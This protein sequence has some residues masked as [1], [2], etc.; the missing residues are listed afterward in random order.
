MAV[1]DIN[2]FSMYLC[3]GMD[4][5]V[6]LPDEIYDEEK[7]KCVWLY[8]GGSGDHKE[9]MYHTPLVDIVNERKFAAVLPNVNESCFVDM[10]IGD[11]YGSYVGKELPK[12]IWKMFNCISGKREDNYVSGLSNGGYGCLHTALKYPENFSV[13][14]AFSAG[15]K[16]DADFPNDGGE[17]SINR[18]RLYGDGD[19]HNTEYSII[20]LADKLC[21]RYKTEKDAPKLS[22]Y[23]GCGN[24]DPWLDMNHIVR[25]YF[26]KHNEEFNYIYDEPEGLGHEWK[27]W[28]LE[29][30]KFLDFAGIK[31]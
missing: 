3:H 18:I 20:Y 4:V 28:N 24:L 9:W 1:V 6:V 22:I 21:E 19:I 23:H 7:L 8:H 29:L 12:I 26:I 13:V 17:K 11:K 15:D 25:D 16:A 5:T 14:G 31:G 27:L 2:L 10:N 30:E